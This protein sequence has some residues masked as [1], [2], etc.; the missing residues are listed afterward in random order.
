MSTG[1]PIC[2]GENVLL[3]QRHNAAPGMALVSKPTRLASRLQALL[4]AGC[5]GS[6]WVA[7]AVLALSRGGAMKGMG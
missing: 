5:H 2:G 6:H 4:G 7:A 1:K 3:Q